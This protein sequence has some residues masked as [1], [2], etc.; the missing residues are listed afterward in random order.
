MNVL[1]QKISIDDFDLSLA[2]LRVINPDH[3]SAIMSQMHLHGQLQPIVVRLVEGRYQ[4]IDGHKRYYA[5]M[6]LALKELK[7]YVLDV[8]LQQAKVLVISYNRNGQSLEV[9][10]EAM[11]L[12]DL[13]SRH[14]LN[15]S[16]L[17]KL[18][19]Y[20]RCWVSRRLSLL[21]KLS[22]ELITEIRMGTLS[23]SQARAL[24]K[25]PRG[26]Q[27]E[28]ARVIMS[29]GFSSRQTDVLVE[30]FLKAKDRPEQQYILAHPELSLTD[31]SAMHPM[32]AY[33]QRLSEFGNELLNAT[34]DALSV[35]GFILWGLGPEQKAVLQKTE[36]AI[37]APELMPLDGE[38]QKLIKSITELYNHKPPEKNER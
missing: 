14:G 33:D 28:V 30:A 11:V 21:S 25:L 27:M 32:P 8:D 4:I 1:L 17:S 22:G 31:N 10:E 6:E 36:I 16:A 9:W 29:W 2:G 37:I 7:C 13:I 15:Q 20:S 18:I 23:S 34:R 38:A 3:V 5:A 24:I 35:I 26:N 12:A 19:G